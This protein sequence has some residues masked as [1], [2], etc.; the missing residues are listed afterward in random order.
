MSLSPP[1]LET[2]STNEK[3]E[4]GH[5]PITP[6]GGHD[7][8]VLADLGYKQ[9]LK[10]GFSTLENFG[11]SF[12]IISVITGITTQFAFGLSNGGPGVMSVGWIIVSCFTMIVALAMAEV[13]SAVPT[14]GGPYH[15]AALLTRPSHSPFAAYCTGFYNLL[16]QAAVTAGIVYGCSGLIATLA[17]LHNFEVTAAKEVGISAA[18]LVFGGLVNTFGIKLL[19]HLNRVSIAL[20]SVGVASIVIALLAK[21]PTHRTA[22]EVFGTFNDASG[23]SERASPAYVAITGILLSQYTMTGFDASAHMSEETANAASAAPK[24]VLMSVAASAVFGF[25]V[26]VSFLFCIQD[27]DGTI[28]PA[29]GNPV[30]QIFIDVFGKTGA[31]AAFSIIILCV[32]LCGTFSITS[33]SRMYFACSR[34]SLLPKYFAHVNERFASPIRTVWLAVVLAFVLILPALGSTV[35]FAAVTAIA[36]SGLYI[37]YALPIVFR[38]LENERFLSI[39]GPFYLGRFSRPIAF[40]CVV[41]VCFITVVFCL[42]TTTPVTSQTLNYTP[43]ALGTVAAYIAVSWFAFA[44]KTFHG[45]RADALKEAARALGESGRGVNEL[46]REVTTDSAFKKSDRGDTRV[47]PVDTQEVDHEYK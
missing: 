43:I 22:K 8:E 27:F 40:A 44:R 2:V 20:H 33:N 42:P 4:R 30:L 14:S 21:A 3:I 34:D 29:A 46:E 19:A 45:P 11:I 12:T 6:R 13:V 31:T 26:L 32:V 36:T 10:R 15:W 16:G 18:L 47:R 39:R 25:F 28:D 1:R 38:L 9:E 5:E 17:S 35:A 23:W 37:S 41:Y 7:G 24:G